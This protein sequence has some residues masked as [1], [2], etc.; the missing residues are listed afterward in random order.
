M[1]FE[2][3]G[4]Y[5]IDKRIGRGGM[6]TVF[7]ATADVT[8]ER[9]AVKVL[10]SAF[11]GDVGLN[12]R[13]AAEIESLRML[14][15]PNIVRIFGYGEDNEIR[16]YAMELI[17]GQSLQE[18]LDAKRRFSWPDVAKIGVQI[19][20][21]LKHAHDHGIVH[22][23]I[24]PANLLITADGSVKLSDFGIAKLFGNTGMT[25]D[26][27]VIG[28]AEYMAPEQADGRTATSRAD[29][30]SVG[31]VLY[32]LL[33]GKPPFV[34]RSLLEMLQLQRFADPEPPIRRDPQIPRALND[35][36]LQLLVKDPA[37]RTPT[38][39]VVSR[40][41]ESLL[42]AT[43]R[44]D[45][46]AEQTANAAEP[47]LP[48]PAN[49]KPAT[50]VKL[51]GGDPKRTSGSTRGYATTPGLEDHGFSIS[52]DV[53]APPTGA[54]AEKSAEPSGVAEG[55][56][57]ATSEFTGGEFNIAPLDLPARSSPRRTQAEAPGATSGATARNEPVKRVPNPV[58]D[59]P[60]VADQP[61]P[62]VAK[63]ATFAGA[64]VSA[65]ATRTFTPINR[66]ERRRLEDELIE[67]AVWVS[68]GTWVLAGSM[69][70]LGLLAWYWLQPPAAE[71]LF[72]RIQTAAQEGDVKRLIDVERDI[73]DFIDY[74]PADRRVMQMQ[75][76]LDEIDLYRLEKKFEFR[77]KFLSKNDG[78]SPIERAYFEAIG[79]L[80]LQPALGRRKMA[81]LV[82]L[83]RDNNDGTKQTRD[84]LVLA[85]R[86][87]AKL[88]RQAEEN[89][90]ADRQVVDRQLKRA[91][92]LSTTDVDAAR[93]LWSAIIELYGDEAWAE[94]QVG[95]ARRALDNAAPRAAAT[96]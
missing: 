22:R 48:P 12:D 17:E 49:D 13:F 31:G 90:V 9:A 27:G 40:Q 87:L 23:D 36:I 34:A 16:Y 85:Q 73:N 76:Y 63:E 2:R 44:K 25:A 6:G 5:K 66:E 50:D 84:C 70:I 38:A 47:S 89:A 80:N 33:L 11:Q 59:T 82:E 62:A 37:K 81:A 78:L 45:G 96:K 46:P 72:D 14:R 1:Q 77:A 7:A 68:P 28:T 30:Y 21:A 94:E 88:D 91:E 75:A 86:Q 61:K 52:G 3:L 60:A 35:L 8:G 55:A 24:K 58:A 57:G 71:K 92:S 4:P 74:Y 29:L 39:L 20:R 32:A 95:Q 56:L 69:L 93:R 67:P 41:L 19:C 43:A 51:A 83:Y 10:S 79:Y 15:H 42:A 65:P 53:A 26:G 18:A 64:V 54:D